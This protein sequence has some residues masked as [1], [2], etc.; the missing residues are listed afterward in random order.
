MN[1]LKVLKRQDENL[2]RQIDSLTTE[3]L[4]A[5]VTMLA[6]QP[7]TSKCDDS[8]FITR[9]KAVAFLSHLRRRSPGFVPD[10]GA[11]RWSAC[12]FLVS[13]AVV[14]NG[15]AARCLAGKVPSQA[16]RRV[17]VRRRDHGPAR[18]RANA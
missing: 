9:A 4:E 1:L 17:P 5:L 10:F 11:L 8:P 18:R 13:A 15:F 6:E 12:R 3:S 7:G 2:L 16:R 14:A